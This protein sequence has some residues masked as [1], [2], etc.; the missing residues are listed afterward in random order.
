MADALDELAADYG[1]FRAVFQWSASP[2]GDLELG[3]R[4]AGALYRFWIAR[5]HLSEAR[6]WLESALTHGVT[7]SPRVRA[8]AL[9][10]AGVMA[11][12]QH[13]GDVA[14]AHLAQSLALWEELGDVPREASAALNLGSVAKDRGDLEQAE[15]RLSQA[16]ALFARCEDLRGQAAALGSRASV[17]HQRGD[18][19]R[20]RDLFEQ[21]LPLSRE[22]GDRWAVAN[23]LANL[24]HVRL[25]LD[26]KLGAQDAF[27]KSLELRRELGN[28]L[29]I[30]ESLEGIAGIMLDEQPRLAV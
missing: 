24:G 15:Q 20:A 1:N 12:M 13:D 28:V 8:I 21:S 25:A 14:M 6:A 29:H 11:G 22:V 16:Q 9:H 7:A 10:A 2:E 19:E 30:A 18:L 4:L 26:D 27:R 23:T 5:G 3:L 17:A